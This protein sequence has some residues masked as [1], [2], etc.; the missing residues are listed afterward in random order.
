MNIVLPFCWFTGITFAESAFLN[1]CK[2]AGHNSGDDIFM[3]GASRME[4]N[5]RR[6][7]AEHVLAD[8]FVLSIFDASAATCTRWLVSLRIFDCN[9]RRSATD[10]AGV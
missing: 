2:D 10:F 4:K 6:F 9:E 3:I 7:L 5:L 1:S 8:I